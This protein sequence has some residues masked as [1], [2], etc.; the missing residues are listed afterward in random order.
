MKK[1][2]IR[3]SAHQTKDISNETHRE[4]TLEEA[5]HDGAENDHLRQSKC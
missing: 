4:N 1:H 2:H 5:S 3:R